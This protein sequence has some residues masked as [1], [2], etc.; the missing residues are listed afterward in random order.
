[1]TKL[2]EKLASIKNEIG[3]I[4]KQTENGKN[5]PAIQMKLIKL[6]FGTDTHSLM[7]EWGVY[8]FYHFNQLSK[9]LKHRSPRQIIEAVVD[10]K[11][12]IIGSPPAGKKN[13]YSILWFASPLFV[14]EKKLMEAMS[15]ED[16]PLEPA[17]TA[18]ES[19]MQGELFASDM[20]RCNITPEGG[21]ILR[22]KVAPINCIVNY[23]GINNII[24][25]GGKRLAS[26]G[27][28]E[29]A[30]NTSSEG[31]PEGNPDGCSAAGQETQPG[32]K[33]LFSLPEKVR[34]QKVLTFIE[35]VRHSQANKDIFQRI[36]ADLTCPS[37]NGLPIPGAEKFTPDEAREILR[38]L[39]YFH[40]K[41]YFMNSEKFF[42]YSSFSSRMGWLENLLLSGM[43]RR[44]LTAAIKQFKSK[45]AREL[46]EQQAQE[47]Q[48]RRSHRPI[49][50]HEWMEQDQRYY[51]DPVD[52]I[53]PIPADAPPRPSDQAFWN[54]FRL[55]WENGT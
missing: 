21:A 1:M 7:N 22:C 42:R 39:M 36:T 53:L 23:T 50:P 33:S 27:A 14:S 19:L 35:Q 30:E 4:I 15:R 10:S 49:S 41:K 29:S 55:Q 51:Q 32:G 46:R 11:M 31:S 38:L 45:R 28:E 34:E 13:F 2:T 3:K 52:G 16:A 26:S 24:L 54:R 40:V 47:E 5:S 43:G 18:Q 17:D 9:V 6:Y 12:F 37:K 44:L 48:N 25:S 20:T 8:P